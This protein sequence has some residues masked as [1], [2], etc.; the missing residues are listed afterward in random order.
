MWTPSLRRV[1]V[2]YSSRQCDHGRGPTDE[3]GGSEAAGIQRQIVENRR[4]VLVGGS[5]CAARGRGCTFL[6]ERGCGV[7]VC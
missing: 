1:S 6:L 4:A 7:L 3:T 5:K 2:G